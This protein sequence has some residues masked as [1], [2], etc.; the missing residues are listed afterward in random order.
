MGIWISCMNFI[1][2]SFD[3]VVACSTGMTKYIVDFPGQLVTVTGNVN[4]DEVY[5]RI[6]K[7]GKQVE[8]VP[9]PPPPAPKKEEP[10]KEEKKEEN[11]E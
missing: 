2:V 4:P 9:P 1:G 6:K 7:T 11:K 10:K 3:R 8:L 5:R